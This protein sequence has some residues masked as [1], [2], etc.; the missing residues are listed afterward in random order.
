MSGLP[1]SH[2]ELQIA[3]RNQVLGVAQ[4]LMHISNHERQDIIQLIRQSLNSGNVESLLLGLVRCSR[5]LTE[6]QNKV[7]R[8]LLQKELPQPETTMVSIYLLKE[9][10]TPQD[11]LYKKLQKKGIY[12]PQKNMCTMDFLNALLSGEKLFFTQKEVR[13][14][15]PPH[16]REFAVVRYNHYYFDPGCFRYL[17][18]G[19]GV[20]RPPN[21]DFLFTIINTVYP[22]QIQR[23]IDQ[24]LA[25][26]RKQEPCL[27]IRTLFAS[28]LAAPETFETI[29]KIPI[30]HSLQKRKRGRPKCQITKKSSKQ[31]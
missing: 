25:S 5:T 11:S 6:G 13:Q 2:E 18:L 1:L 20:S 31:L 9:L 26:H 24:V 7:L 22:G 16:L 28:L 27:P 14:V 17:P 21:R 29:V 30:K 3:N 19:L 10:T 15:S 23:E 8:G 12:L 4:Y